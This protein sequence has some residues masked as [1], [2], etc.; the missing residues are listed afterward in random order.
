MSRSPIRIGLLGAG[1]IGR[2]HAELVAWRVP[3]LGLAAVSDVSTRAAQALARDLAVEA[4]PR[5]R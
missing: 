3:G 2:M 1:R 5:R 4:V